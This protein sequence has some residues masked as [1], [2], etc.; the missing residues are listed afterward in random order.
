[1]NYSTEIIST[2]ALTDQSLESIHLPD[3]WTFN[4]PWMHAARCTSASLHYANM[5]LDLAAEHVDC[6]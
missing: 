6:S 1:M 3:K 2:A 5:W 4:F